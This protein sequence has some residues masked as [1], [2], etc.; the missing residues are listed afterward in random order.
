MKKI[1]FSLFCHL[2]EWGAAWAFGKD[3]VLGV[4]V[5]RITVF[6]LRHGVSRGKLHEV[7]DR[8]CV[9]LWENR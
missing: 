4:Y 3:A 7:I 8:C 2:F 5:G 6:S 9:L 1:F